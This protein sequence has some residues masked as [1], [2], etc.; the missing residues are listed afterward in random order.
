MNSRI[1]LACSVGIVSFLSLTSCSDG[2]TSTAEATVSN[3][4]KSE[5]VT[6]W[7]NPASASEEVG[8]V[9]PGNFVGLKSRQNVKDEN[10][11]DLGW[12]H[13]DLPE[14][15]IDEQYVDLDNCYQDN[16]I[17]YCMVID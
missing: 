6:L 5:P 1:I 9:A 7:K 4:Q 3:I 14:A 17:N 16:E 8:K 2:T 13:V 11:N 10:G 12:Y 15:Y